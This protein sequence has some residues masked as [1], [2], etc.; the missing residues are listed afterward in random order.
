MQCIHACANHVSIIKFHPPSCLKRVSC[1]GGFFFFYHTN[2]TAF[3]GLEEH[4]TVACGVCLSNRPRP[5]R[6]RQPLKAL[7]S[8]DPHLKATF[9]SRRRRTNQRTLHAVRCRNEYLAATRDWK[10]VLDPIMFSILA[11]DEN[12]GGSS[13]SHLTTT[14]LRWRKEN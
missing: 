8:V 1:N 4:Y 2:L 7:T 5:T 11:C 6:A 9:C 3:R 10:V 14:S 12:G 13:H